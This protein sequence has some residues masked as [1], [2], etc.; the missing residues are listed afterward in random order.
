MF[1]FYRQ[2]TK[3]QKGAK[4][5]I[6]PQ[7]LE[8][9]ELRQIPDRPQTRTSSS[10]LLSRPKATSSSLGTLGGLLRVD[11]SG[12]LGAVKLSASLISEGAASMQG[13]GPSL[14]KTHPPLPACRLRGKSQIGEVKVQVWA[15][16]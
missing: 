9:A 6:S 1:L 7:S 5:C 12:K 16:P 8:V 14:I 4:T 2:E 3:A 10:A 13:I 11:R 15:H